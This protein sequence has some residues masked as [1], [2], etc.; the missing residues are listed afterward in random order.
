M[1]GGSSRVIP[2]TH[3]EQLARAVLSQTNSVILVIEPVSRLVIKMLG[4]KKK[5]SCSTRS[6]DPFFG[7]TACFIF[8]KTNL[9]GQIQIFY[10]LIWK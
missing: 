1:L 6:I 8:Q 9:T 7:K 5:M 10:V 4:G 2:P 3:P